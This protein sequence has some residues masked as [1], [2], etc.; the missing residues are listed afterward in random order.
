M[1]RLRGVEEEEDGTVGVEGG[2]DRGDCGRQPGVA[3]V[4]YYSDCGVGIRIEGDEK[5]AGFHGGDG[6]DGGR[7]WRVEVAETVD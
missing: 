2:E 4:V 3:R 5:L 7:R 6:R 1:L